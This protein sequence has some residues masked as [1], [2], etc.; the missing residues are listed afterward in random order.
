MRAI[1]TAAMATISVTTGATAAMPF[2]EA[3]ISGHIAK[4][5]VGDFARW[6]E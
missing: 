5:P 3:V 2:N 1:F 4:S 6:H